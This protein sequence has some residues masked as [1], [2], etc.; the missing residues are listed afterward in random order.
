MKLFLVVWM[1]G[2]GDVRKWFNA[3]GYEEAKK[4]GGFGGSGWASTAKW[5]CGSKDFFV[6][7]SSRSANRM[8]AGEAAGLGAMRAAAGSGLAIPE[9]FHA[10]DYEDGRGSFIIMEYLRLGGRGDAAALGRAMAE[11]HLAPGPDAYGF[12]VDNTIGATPQPNGWDADWIRFW[13]EKRMKHQLKLAGDSAIQNVA[14]KLIP[15][16]PEF[17][18]DG[19]PTRPAII[20]GDLWSGNIGTADGR[21]SIY[22]P[23]CYY[24]HHEAEWG[25]SWCASLGPA[26]WAA[27]RSLIPEAPGFKKRRPLYEAYHQLNHYNLFG[28]GYRGAAISCMEDALRFLKP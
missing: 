12:D 13:T 17:F 9:V 15:R 26:F 10:G 27:Y 28:G 24:A 22:D 14:E 21:P 19:E 2:D 7:S 20:H 5:T 4:S 23:A 18:D 8:F 25:M 3:N 1:G 6:K 11:M 16:I